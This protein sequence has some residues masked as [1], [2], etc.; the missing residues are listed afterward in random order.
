[1]NEAMIIRVFR[2]KVQPGKQAE[3]LRVLEEQGIPHFRSHPGM[4]GVHVGTPTEASPDEFLVTTLWKDLDALRTFAGER[5][6]EAKILPGERKLLR[7]AHVHHYWTEDGE[8]WP[9]RAPEV[10]EAGPL[11]VDLSRRTARIRGREVD[12]PPREFAV[13]AELASHPEEPVSSAD[14]AARVWPDRTWMNADDVRRVVYS[15]RRL[16]GDDRRERPLI[17]NRRGHGYVL[18]LPSS[19]RR[20]RGDSGRTEIGQNFHSPR[21]GPRGGM[22]PWVDP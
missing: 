22:S 4:L 3:F 5:W 1:M 12:L 10:I 18:D 9:P 13:L 15:L 16:L 11:T 6:Y 20:G 19:S 14:L 7:S 21:R 2:G 8:R 17:R